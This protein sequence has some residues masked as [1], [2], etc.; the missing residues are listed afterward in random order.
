MQLYCP[1]CCE[2][3]A[4]IDL[5]LHNPGTLWCQECEAEFTTDDV[6]D[7][8]D[9]ARKWL[10]VVAWIDRMPADEEETADRPQQHETYPAGSDLPL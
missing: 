7:L 10:K 4:N 5:R 9:G 2:P 3:A 6:R 1:K 8:I